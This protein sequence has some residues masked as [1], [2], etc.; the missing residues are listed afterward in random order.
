[1]A[2]TATMTRF[3]LK[4]PEFAD[5]TIYSSELLDVYIADASLEPSEVIWGNKWTQG[6]YLLTA[7]G[8]SLWK[9]SQAATA[10][11][12]GASVGGVNS[13]RTGDESINFG[14]VGAATASAGEASFRTTPYGLEYI[15]MRSELVTTPF[16]V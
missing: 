7:H 12:F 6:V 8:L 10:N 4:F 16:C 11:A 13:I 15:R 1:M 14:A 3:R 9:R 5:D 2:D